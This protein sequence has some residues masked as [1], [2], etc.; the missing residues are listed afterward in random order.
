[1][2]GFD[3]AAALVEKVGRIALA[4]AAN[5]GGLTLLPTM[6]TASVTDSGV[7]SARRSMM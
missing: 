2:R 1:M 6:R 4:M 5:G 3:Q 7:P